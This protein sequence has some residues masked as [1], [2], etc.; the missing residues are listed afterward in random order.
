MAPESKDTTEAQTDENKPTETPQEKGG[1]ADGS[2]EKPQRGLTEEMKAFI[3]KEVNMDMDV[4][5]LPS[6][7]PLRK[8]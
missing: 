3:E 8:N 7:R 5:D 1:D 4:S 2:P 6:S